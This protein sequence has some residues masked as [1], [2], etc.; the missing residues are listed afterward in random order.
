KLDP[1]WPSRNWF[2]TGTH[3]YPGTGENARRLRE[4]GM[5][6]LKRQEELKSYLIKHKY[7]SPKELRITNE[8]AR[9]AIFAP[10]LNAIPSWE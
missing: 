5:Q 2:I 4:A 10:Y 9:R 3:A 6:N 7:F 8:K 1:A